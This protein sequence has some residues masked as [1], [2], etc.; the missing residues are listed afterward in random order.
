MPAGGGAARRCITAPTPE[1]V[2][3]AAAAAGPQPVAA[4]TQPFQPADDAAAFDALPR[5][6]V[7]CL[8]DRAIMPAHA[9]ADVHGRRL[10][11]GDRDRHRPLA[12]AVANR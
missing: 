4:F 11:P 6:Y 5:A 10:R 12:V 7:T 1:R 2:A 3:W 9:A 8:Q